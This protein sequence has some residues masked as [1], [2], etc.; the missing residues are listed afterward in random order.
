MATQTDTA[1]PAHTL[2]ELLGQVANQSGDWLVALQAA[3]EIAVTL[4]P[5]EPVVPSKDA[6]GRKIYTM[7][8]ETADGEPVLATHWMLQTGN[9][10]AA[11]AG[12]FDTD[13]HA[14]WD[15]SGVTPEEWM[16]RPIQKIPQ[17]GTLAYA[18][19]GA[20]SGT[21]LDV[22]VSVG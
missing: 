10:W 15:G 3:Q 8:S 5:E 9:T 11:V 22:E 19:E 4:S 16:R 7:N 20:E 18:V 1:H 14:W 13:L 2:Q 17:M 21:M 12:A 6:E